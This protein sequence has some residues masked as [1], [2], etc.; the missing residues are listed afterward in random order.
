MNKYA[1]LN[2]DNEKLET[3]KVLFKFDGYKSRKV[4]DFK[5]T[6]AVLKNAVPISSNI[7]KH[8]EFRDGKYRDTI[9][10]GSSFEDLCFYKEDGDYIFEAEDDNAAKLIYEIGEY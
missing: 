2:F 9:F 6:F 1:I 10:S 5:C 4:K 3:E 7:P 8:L